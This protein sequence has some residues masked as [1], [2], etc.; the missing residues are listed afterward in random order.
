MFNQSAESGCCRFYLYKMF[1]LVFV[2][3]YVTLVDCLLNVFFKGSR[4]VVIQR[5]YL[6]FLYE[7]IDFMFLCIFM[8]YDH[9][10][11]FI[12]FRYFVPME[13]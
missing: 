8:Y 5:Y 1:L 7:S 9:G 12:C 11:T 10:S 6:I 13:F 4:G 2:Y 3:Y